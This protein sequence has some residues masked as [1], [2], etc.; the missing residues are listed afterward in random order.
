MNRDFGNVREILQNTEPSLAA[1][2]IEPVIDR[3]TESLDALASIRADLAAR[4][5]SPAGSLAELLKPAD[6]DSTGESDDWG[7]RSS[8]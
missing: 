2:L 5:E 6:P 4:C 3:F 8:G 1:S 7:N